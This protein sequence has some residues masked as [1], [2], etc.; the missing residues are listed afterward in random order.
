MP[1]RVDR[2][3][4]DA[5]LVPVSGH[6]VALVIDGG[7]E[8][9]MQDGFVDHVFLLAQEHPEPV[10][11]RRLRD[12]EFHSNGR[13]ILA[14]GSGTQP[15]VLALAAP[16]PQRVPQIDVMPTTP[17]NAERYEG[18]GLSRRTAAWSV[19]LDEILTRG[20]AELIPACGRTEGQPGIASLSTCSSGGPGSTACSTTCLTASGGDCST[21]CGSGYY[22]CCNQGD[23]TC[24]CV[25]NPSSGGGE[26]KPPIQDPA[27]VPRGR[28]PRR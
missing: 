17:D 22:A 4:G 19:P 2:I 10:Q 13:V 18:Y 1:G 6:G 15:L 9:G 25:Q 3:A 26:P 27:S 7:S 5:W 16:P 24:T 8:P 23:C 14:Q 11:P 12:A 20:V 28:V 21:S